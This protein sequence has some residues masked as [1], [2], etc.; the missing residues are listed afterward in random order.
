MLTQFDHAYT[1]YTD[2]KGGN[3]SISDALMAAVWYGHIHI[4]QSIVNRNA[5][6]NAHTH[7]GLTALHF[8]V[9]RRNAL[10]VEYLLLCGASPAVASNSGDT[11]LH[12][13]VDFIPEVALPVIE[14][15][16]VVGHVASI[17][18]HVQIFVGEPDDTVAQIDAEYL[19]RMAI[20]CMLVLFDA[21]IFAK[22]NAEH[23]PKTLALVRNDTH[24]AIL[25]SQLRTWLSGEHEV[26]VNGFIN[27]ALHY[28]D[29][30]ADAINDEELLLAHDQPGSHMRPYIEKMDWSCVVS[31]DTVPTRFILGDPSFREHQQLASMAPYPNIRVAPGLGRL[32]PWQVANIM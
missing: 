24:M 18:R 7:Y 32:F 10:M 26:D 3:V 27:G 9:H 20:A 30:C 31:H 4:V 15:L 29:Q 17:F 8:A 2:H 11:P 14:D 28:I 25:L 23:T 1:Y 13:I 16:D 22:N 21:D 6:V 19:E 5:D 12:C